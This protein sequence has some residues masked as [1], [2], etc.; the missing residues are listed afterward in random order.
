L[1]DENPTGTDHANFMACDYNIELFHKTVKPHLGF[2]EGATSGFAAV[3]SHVHW[4]YCA[5]ILLGMSPPGVS[6]GV[7][8]LGDQQR[9]LQQLLA[10]QEK[11][12]VLRQLP[13]IGGVQRYKDELRQALT[14]A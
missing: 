8:S 11:R 4:V 13:Q 7:K 1:K 2:E 10:N 12:R 3:M 5:H 6:A 14:A 9:P